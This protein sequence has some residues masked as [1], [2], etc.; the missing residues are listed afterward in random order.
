M[1]RLVRCSSNSRCCH[2]STEAPFKSASIP[3]VV[4]G[5]ARPASGRQG[6]FGRVCPLKYTA[7]ELTHEKYPRQREA[8]PPAIPRRRLASRPSAASRGTKALRYPRAA[9]TVALE[10]Q[11]SRNHFRA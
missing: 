6:T 10:R 3:E 8:S 4:E 1:S 11:L 5:V 2:T 7:C 9:A